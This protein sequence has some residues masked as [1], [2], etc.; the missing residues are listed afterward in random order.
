MEDAL[1]DLPPPTNLSEDAVLGA[2]CSAACAAT[3]A[4]AGWLIAIDGDRLRVV[5]SRGD[6]GGRVRGL[7]VDVDGS[8]GLVAAS[9]QPMAITPRPGDQNVVGGVLGAIGVVPGS[10]LALP[11]HDTDEVV[12][13]LELVDKA[14]GQRFSFDDVEFASLLASVAGAALCQRSEMPVA[15]PESLAIQLG[16]L[17]GADPARYAQVAW[18]IAQ[19]LAS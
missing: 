15:T 16:V 14:G 12:G 9:G 3:G 2:V 10:L 8:A 11:C 4:A 13:V 19:L 17:A 6:L 7:V 1:P 5:A 18:V